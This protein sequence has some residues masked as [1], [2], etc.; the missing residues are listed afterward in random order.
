MGIETGLAAIGTFLGA[1]AASAT[2][3]GALAAGAVGSTALNAYTGNK[4]A[5]AQRDATNQATANAK[6]TAT[7]A[8]QANNKANQKKPDSDALL[9]AN[10]T[11]GQNGQA[12]TMLTGPAGIDPSTLTLGKTT[13]LGGGG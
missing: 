10:L 13:L 6:A 12:S 11:A 9:S 4:Q 1:S 7:A 8:E 3:V 2:A 5:K